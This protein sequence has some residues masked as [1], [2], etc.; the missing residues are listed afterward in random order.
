MRYLKRAIFNL[1]LTSE[2]RANLYG[3]L[4]SMTGP[5]GGLALGM[6]L[7]EM[8]DE[9]RKQKHYLHPLILEIIRRMKGG[10]AKRK[11]YSDSATK[12]LRLGDV[13][14][15]L[16]P[17]NEAML[18]RSGEEQGNIS[19][20]LAQAATHASGQSELIQ[21]IRSGVSRFVLYAV[22]MVAIYFLFS[23]EI[24]P[25]MDEA[26]PRSKWSIA[27]QRFG[28]IADHIIIVCIGFLLSLLLLYIAFNFM[29]KNLTGRTR[30]FLDKHIWPFTTVRLMNSSATL[31]SLSGFLRTGVPF[32]TAL[33]SM[34]EGADP[35]MMSKLDHI[36]R[37]TQQGKEPHI[38]LTTSDLFPEEHKWI[39]RVYGRTTDFG[40]ALENIAK[41][42][43]D[44]AIK[45]AKTTAV[46]AEILGTLAIAFSILWIAA[47][48][49][50][51]V[52]S[53][54]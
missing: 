3:A 2:T 44:L 18:I 5:A 33:M 31:S 43:Y 40:S 10:G 1:R 15:G 14:M 12:T 27:A 50:G 4:A 20:G 36:K 11:S 46:I 42:F 54:K 35:Y 32:K 24:L 47:T 13:L 17:S 48:I 52:G 8:E 21:I 28:Y 49:Y 41:Q 25:Q 23:I 29:R 39:I 30:A 37:L 51:I 26:V 9:F 22:M 6:A 16:V 7:S 45:K 38:A 34:S 53:L 19:Y